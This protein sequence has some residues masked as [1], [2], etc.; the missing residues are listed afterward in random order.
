[1]NDYYIRLNNWQRFLAGLAE[2]RKISTATLPSKSLEAKRYLANRFLAS[3]G[4][5]EVKAL[6]GAP[7]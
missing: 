3:R 4:I 5:T 6:Y 1:M 2:Q 7:I